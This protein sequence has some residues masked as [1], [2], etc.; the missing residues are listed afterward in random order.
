M[1]SIIIRVTENANRYLKDFGKNSMEVLK[2]IVHFTKPDS[3]LRKLLALDKKIK[4]KW[5]IYDWGTCR[6]QSEFQAKLTIHADMNSYEFGEEDVHSSS[7]E[8]ANKKEKK[9]K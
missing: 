6:F 5:A 9:Q 7:E 1:H 8:G 3:D 4:I 2:W